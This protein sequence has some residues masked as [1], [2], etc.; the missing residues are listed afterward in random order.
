MNT[1]VMLM[2]RN[3]NS[4]K[5]R[6]VT[7]VD[8]GIDLVFDLMCGFGMILLNTPEGAYYAGNLQNN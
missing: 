3:V 8:N 6:F 1:L 2:S 4:H 7:F 5:S